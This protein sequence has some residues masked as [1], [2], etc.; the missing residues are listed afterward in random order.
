MARPIQVRTDLIF[1]LD[2]YSLGDTQLSYHLNDLLVRVEKIRPSGQNNEIRYGVM[3]DFVDDDSFWKKS[4]I[5]E[6]PVAATNA[7]DRQQAQ[8]DIIDQY[9][10]EMRGKFTTHYAKETNN[11]SGTVDEFDKISRSLDSADGKWNIYRQFR[12]KELTPFSDWLLKGE[13]ASKEALEEE[14]IRSRMG[15]ETDQD[16]LISVDWACPYICY[17]QK[18]SIAHSKGAYGGPDMFRPF[19]NYAWQ[20]PELATK[21]TVQRDT[22]YAKKYQRGIELKANNYALFAF[23]CHVI[24]QICQL[25][26]ENA[27]AIRHYHTYVQ[28]LSYIKEKLKAHGPLASLSENQMSQLPLAD[29]EQDWDGDTDDHSWGNRGDDH[30]GHFALGLKDIDDS[31]ALFSQIIQSESESGRNNERSID[32][33]VLAHSFNLAFFDNDVAKANYSDLW[34][35]NKDPFGIDLFCHKGGMMLCTMRDAESVYKNFLEANLYEHYILDDPNHGYKPHNEELEDWGNLL[36]RSHNITF[37]IWM[38]YYGIRESLIKFDKAQV[39]SQQV[40]PNNPHTGDIAEWFKTNVIHQQDVNYQQ[41]LKASSGTAPQDYSKWTLNDEQV[42]KLANYMVGGGQI[43]ALKN[44]EGKLAS[45]IQHI[46]ANTNFK[47]I[48]F[49]KIDQLHD[50]VL[51]YKEQL[52]TDVPEARV[53]GITHAGNIAGASINL[54]LSGVVFS[55][56]YKPDADSTLKYRAWSMALGVFSD[57]GNTI[58]KFRGIDATLSRTVAAKAG[59]RV[60]LSLGGLQLIGGGVGG[61]L[62]AVWFSYDMIRGVTSGF[63][64]DAL[65]DL[66]SAVGA[67]IGVAALFA[68]GTIWGLPAGAVLGLVSFIMVGTAQLLKFLRTFNNT[69]EDT[70]K[71]LNGYSLAKGGMERFEQWFNELEAQ[72]VALPPS[73]ISAGDEKA[74]EKLIQRVDAFITDWDTYD[75]VAALPEPNQ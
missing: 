28:N 48:P 56:A 66:A 16:Y 19:H 17:T 7:V 67:A 39:F 69:T 57:V 1:Q 32:I 23:Y 15:F 58:A 46:F 5:L 21:I 29:L 20:K 68:T 14:L 49:D 41:G 35:F 62:G 9:L 13:Y 47:D 18:G 45:Q 73:I 61:V 30:I 6:I 33:E 25:Q 60:A 10:N 34:C 31:I 3:V 75:K 42:R 64:K 50:H 2:T 37:N 12:T 63:E 4:Y 40:V 43:D 36:Y 71:Q 59:G 24:D 27:E 52:V 72:T 26:E 53:G 11:E 74:I 44:I 38:A 54:L 55:N 22:Q 8:E 51:A 70:C 65:L